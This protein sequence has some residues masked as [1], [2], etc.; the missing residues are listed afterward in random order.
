M[1]R[2]V[3]LVLGAVLLAAAP[4]LSYTVVFKDGTVQIAREKYTV[5]GNKAI[6]T[7]RNGTVTQYDLEKIDVPGT[8]EY[9]EENPG[10]AI[11]LDTSNEK[12]T[13]TPQSTPVAV[14]GQ[15]WAA[16]DQPIQATFSKF[17]EGAR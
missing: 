16:V 4:A 9:N 7:L 11:A 14:N 3:G 10:D 1:K 8:D 6:I 5:K 13:P 2:T 17:F 15:S 12:A